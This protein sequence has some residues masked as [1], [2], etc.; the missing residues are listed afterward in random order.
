MIDI[1]HVDCLPPAKQRSIFI[2]AE[3]LRIKTILTKGNY[4]EIA[5]NFFYRQWELFVDFFLNCLIQNI[6]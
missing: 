1:V 5:A 2:I 3:S 4:S 6:K